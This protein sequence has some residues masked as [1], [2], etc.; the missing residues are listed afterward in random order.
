MLKGRDD[1]GL[2]GEGFLFKLPESGLAVTKGSFT[3]WTEPEQPRPREPYLIIIEIRLKDKIKRYR[4]NDLS[5]T[6]TGSDRYRQ[7]I[8]Y[9][10][11][12]PDAS[13]YTDETTRMKKLSGSEQLKVRDNK[14]QLA[15]R[16]PGARQLVRDT[17][18]LKSR[19]LRETQTL[20]LVF[21][22]N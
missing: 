5:G 1:E 14:V 21:G 3:V 7:R 8:P 18:Q 9:D 19:R 10:A 13:F 22:G 2:E 11:R 12:T 15:I 4:I 6:V 20:E 17:I 16:V